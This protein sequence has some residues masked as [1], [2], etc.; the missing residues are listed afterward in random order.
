MGSTLSHL[1]EVENSDSPTANAVAHLVAIGDS[2]RRQNQIDQ[3]KATLDACRALHKLSRVKEA[4]EIMGIRGTEIIP[5]LVNILRDERNEGK[6]Y[7]LKDKGYQLLS[8][9]LVYF[10]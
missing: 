1:D 4:R 10:F 3:E 9:Q 2:F 5:N 6:S 8:S 7:R